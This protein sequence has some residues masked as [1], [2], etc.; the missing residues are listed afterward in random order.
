LD[1]HD[2]Q[3]EL[4]VLLHDLLHLEVRVVVQVLELVYLLFK[5]LDPLQQ[6]FLVRAVVGMEP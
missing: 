2:G 6:S 5:L 1:V 3:V 4:G